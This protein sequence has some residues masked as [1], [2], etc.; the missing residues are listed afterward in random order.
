MRAARN[1]S[2][3]TRPAA[4]VVAGHQVHVTSFFAFRSRSITTGPECQLPTRLQFRL[5]DAT[6]IVAATIRGGRTV[7]ARVR[8]LHKGSSIRHTT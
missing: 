3:A 4:A 8:S 1:A 2:A 5:C 7:C 6:A